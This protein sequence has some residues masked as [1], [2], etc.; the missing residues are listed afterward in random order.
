MKGSIL[1][2]RKMRAR[3]IVVGRII[4][5]QMAQVSFA[6]HHDMVEAFASDRSD[7]PFN[8]T[9]LPW[10][11]WRRSAGRECPWLAAGV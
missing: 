8:M 5:Q 10:R 7:Q 1:V 11:A 3:F 4:C 2:E 9:I 6:E